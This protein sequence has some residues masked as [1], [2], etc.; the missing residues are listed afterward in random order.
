[1]L[2]MFLGPVKTALCTQIVLGVGIFSDNHSSSLADNRDIGVDGP[3]YP[4]VCPCWKTQLW[5]GPG[6]T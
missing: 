1:M 4:E 6:E 5:P 2:G 3:L